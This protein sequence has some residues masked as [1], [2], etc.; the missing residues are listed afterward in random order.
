MASGSFFGFGQ[1]S[2]AQSQTVYNNITNNT[3]CA[4]TPNTLQCLKDLPLAQINQTIYEQDEGQNF[5][6][7]IDGDFFRSYPLVAF[8]NKRLPPIN[9]IVG[10]NSDEGMPLIGQTTANTSAEL[11]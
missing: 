3:G 6:P 4:S 9:I 10:C 1:R 11:S 7:V 2:L 8:E 5:G